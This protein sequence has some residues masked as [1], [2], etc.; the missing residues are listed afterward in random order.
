MSDPKNKNREDE[1]KTRQVKQGTLKALE[2][3]GVTANVL[4]PGIVKTALSHDYMA[5]PVFR[6]FE[7]LIA[8]SP[9]AGARTSLYLAS[10]PEVEGVSG[11]YF[12]KQRAVPPADAV[13]NQGLQERLWE[14]SE[15]LV[16]PRAV[17]T[18]CTLKLM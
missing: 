4:H 7:Q 9:E 10:S 14:V 3:S 15:A 5:N 6:F 2:G 18:L 17:V 13:R 11:Q 12:E 16:E 8:V 1:E